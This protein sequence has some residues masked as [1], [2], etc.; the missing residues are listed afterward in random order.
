MASPFSEGGGV[1]LLRQH[2]KKRDEAWKGP[3]VSE[4]V[5]SVVCVLLVKSFPKWICIKNGFLDCIPLRF[6]N[7]PASNPHLCPKK[8]FQLRQQTIS[9]FKTKETQKQKNKF[10]F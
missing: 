5:E 6:L 8:L 4:Y 3:W 9:Q 7:S 2:I 10:F 1:C